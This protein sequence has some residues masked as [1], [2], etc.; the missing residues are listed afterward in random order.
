MKIGIDI[1]GVI[2]NLEAYHKELGTKFCY[3]NNFHRMI[4]PDEY[5]A[6][7]IFGWDRKIERVFYAKYYSILIYTDRF[8]RADAIEVMQKLHV[9]NEL[10]IITARVE[11]DVPSDTKLNMKDITRHWLINNHIPFDKLIFSK[12]DKTPIINELKLDWMIEDSPI[13]FKNSDIS[14]T[15][16][17][18]FDASYN[19]EL[20]NKRF[21]RAYSWYDIL[22]IIENF[23]RNISTNLCN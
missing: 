13:F 8:L 2:N 3:E 14:H 7:D 19:Q 22:Q 17:I 10:F 4:C 12:A 16:F 20:S 11:T 6:R 18:C 9:N 15:K 21:I 1:D 5:K 23:D